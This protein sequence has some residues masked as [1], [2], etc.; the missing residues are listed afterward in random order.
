[1]EP[2][3][4]KGQVDEGQ[5]GEPL[6][7]EWFL[8]QEGPVRSG[9]ERGGRVPRKERQEVPQFR[10]M[11]VCEWK[12]SQVLPQSVKQKAKSDSKACDKKARDKKAVTKI[13]I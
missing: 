1:M 3:G 11:Q 2:F 4:F 6:R 13:T 10:E 5:E 8:R 12:D 7:E 9:Q